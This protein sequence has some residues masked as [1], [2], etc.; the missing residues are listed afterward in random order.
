MQERQE[1]F[2]CL[3]CGTTLYRVFYD[4]GQPNDGINITT[5]G[6]YGST[7][8][9]DME[10]QFLI[11]NICD[12]CIKEG[13]EQGRIFVGRSY[14]NVMVDTAFG[15]NTTIYS[16]VGSIR[17]DRPYVPFN[18][19][20]YHDGMEPIKMEHDECIHYVEQDKV[21]LHGGLTIESIRQMKAECEKI[22]EMQ[23][24]KIIEFP[25]K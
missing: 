15:P 19:K 5:H 14:V 22:Y 3:I 10:G 24:A 6:N 23:D 16:V 17:A 4:E 7:V 1:D 18:R 12:E 21:R 9:D 8:W 25:E 11:F 20:T 13:S 2:P